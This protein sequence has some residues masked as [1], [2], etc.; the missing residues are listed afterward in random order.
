MKVDLTHIFFPSGM[1]KYCYGDNLNLSL[2]INCPLI[3][4]KINEASLLRS[5]ISEFFNTSHNVI[6]HSYAQVL[7]TSQTRPYFSQCLK[8]PKLGQQHQSM[9]PIAMWNGNQI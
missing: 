6:L 1:L 8:V 9:L 2:I 3:V 4:S 7:N 5:S